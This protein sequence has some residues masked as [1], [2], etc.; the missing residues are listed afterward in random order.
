M[1]AGGGKPKLTKYSPMKA[2][3]INSN[4]VEFDKI[5]LLLGD[6]I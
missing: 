6:I 3:V 4:I 1:G 2:Q 5:F